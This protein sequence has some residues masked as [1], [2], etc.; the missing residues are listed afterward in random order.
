[1]L[2]KQIVIVSDEKYFNFFNQLLKI[3]QFIYC[4]NQI[5]L[6]YGRLFYI[7]HIKIIVYKIPYNQ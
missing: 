6:M 7:E 5:G 2:I 1:M 4:L 3:I